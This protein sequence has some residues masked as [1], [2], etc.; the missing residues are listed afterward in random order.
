LGKKRLAQLLFIAVVILYGLLVTV[1]VVLAHFYAIIS[2]RDRFAVLD[3]VVGCCDV[4]RGCCNSGGCAV[5]SSKSLS[6]CSVAF[7][8]ARAGDLSY[9]SLCAA[10]AASFFSFSISCSL[11]ANIV[12][13]CNALSRSC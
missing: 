13:C 2:S 6:S 11:T 5:S 9:T 4:L 8:T 7:S 1:V 10:I 3:V 12:C